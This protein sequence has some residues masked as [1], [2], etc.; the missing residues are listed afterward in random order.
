M[1]SALF[2]GM[3]SKKALNQAFLEVGRNLG[4]KTSSLFQGDKQEQQFTF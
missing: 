4:I 2:K 3:V 1:Q